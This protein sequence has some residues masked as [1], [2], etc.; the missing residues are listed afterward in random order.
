MNDPSVKFT[1][2]PENVM[3][4][5]EFMHDAGSIKKR[6]AFVERLV[7]PGS[8]RRSR[9]LMSLLTSRASRCNIGTASS[10]SLPHSRSA[11]T[12]PAPID[13]SFSDRP[14]AESLRS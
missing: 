4:Y 11:S 13:S 6:P 5:A 9:K 10:H 3:K 7:F 8:P 12:F 14:D 1:T 2:T